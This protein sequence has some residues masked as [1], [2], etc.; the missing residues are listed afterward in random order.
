[1]HF[2]GQSDGFWPIGLG[3]LII[4]TVLALVMMTIGSTFSFGWHLALSLLVF[5]D[6]FLITI[7]FCYIGSLLG[8]S[9]FFEMVSIISIMVITSLIPT[10]YAIIS[11][12]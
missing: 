4:S 2:K 9:K 8:L 7:T 10:D 5:W 3:W 11:K 12:K 1:M 6:V